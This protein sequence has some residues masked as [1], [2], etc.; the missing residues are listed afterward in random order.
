MQKKVKKQHLVT[1]FP[2]HVRVYPPQGKYTHIRKY[3]HMC[4][5]FRVRI[6]PHQWGGALVSNCMVL[7]IT[8]CKTLG[9]HFFFSQASIK[10]ETVWSR[11]WQEG[12][13]ENEPLV[14]KEEGGLLALLSLV[15]RCRACHPAASESPR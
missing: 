2:S 11:N 5:Y 9:G 3:T 6:Y 7:D 15:G 14:V 4:V 8:L 12:P 10:H 13:L 1:Y